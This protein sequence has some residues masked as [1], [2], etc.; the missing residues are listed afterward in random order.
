M[1]R[2]VRVNKLTSLHLSAPC[3]RSHVK[4]SCTANIKVRQ[5]S[6][7]LTSGTKTSLITPP[8]ADSGGRWVMRDG[9]GGEELSS[10]EQRVSVVH[11]FPV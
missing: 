9:C 7:R 2:G 3:R 6:V 1:E 10:A 8:E 5:L 4:L 11:L